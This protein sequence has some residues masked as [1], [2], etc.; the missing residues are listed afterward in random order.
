M[1]LNKLFI[2]SFICFFSLQVF[3]QDK[4]MDS[5]LKI[6]RT[7]QKDTIG[8]KIYFKVA[9]YYFNH[10]IVDSG[11]VYAKK[12]YSISQK[13][14]Y[15]KGLASAY[16]YFGQVF[17]YS[18]NKD[19]AIYYFSKAKDIF[20]SLQDSSRIAGMFNNMGVVYYKHGDIPKTLSLYFKALKIKERLHD[21]LSC[22]N[23]YYNI[24]NLY[25]EAS[26]TF[27]T[28]KY[29]QMALK[30]RMLVNDLSGIGLSNMAIGLYYQKAERFEQALPYLQKAL[31][32]SE[33]IGDEEAISIG[34]YNLA[35]VYYKQNKTEECLPL[36][37]RSLEISKKNKNYEGI[38]TCLEI[39]GKISLEKNNVSNGI[40][41]LQEAYSFARIIDNKQ[42]I[43]A[44]SN[45]LSS[46]LETKGDF[47]NALL[48]RKIWITIKDSLYNQEN[49]RKLTSEA[50]KYEH[51][52]ERIV[53][54][55]EQE[56][57]EA[58]AKSEGFKKDLIL[59]ASILF[60]IVVSIFTFI[61]LQRLK[62]N[63]KQKNIIEQ[64]RNEM[65]DSI[66]YA[67]RIQFALLAHTDLLKANLPQYFV[68]FRP[69]DIVSGDFYWATKTD[70]FF[71][72]AVCDSTGHGVPG[73]FMSLLNISFL[74]EAINEKN[75]SA[76]NEVLDHVRQRLL[77]NMDGG[78]DGMDAVL[79]KIPIDQP[80]S[81]IEY[82]AANNSPV[83]IRDNKVIELPKDK[84]PVGKGESTINF[85]LQ[86]IEV[87]SGDSFYIYTD[88]FADQFGGAKSKKFKY[89]QLDELLLSINGSS[90]KEQEEVLKKRFEDWMGK[91][92]QVDDV[93]VIGIKI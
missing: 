12:G 11:Y 8:A 38:A 22:S 55:K 36:F 47:K 57:K 67:K 21:T 77:E 34:S 35:S 62:E 65:I 66:N 68:L 37:N 23:S 48:Y 85:N 92:E 86:T 58:I 91:L 16:S 41:L 18:G 89:K 50:L 64:Q 31:T 75:I 26:D 93:C 17:T 70:K 3:S 78:H 28:L 71:Y 69:K 30:L 5:L 42:L 90:L 59:G 49:T 73:A 33:Q 7:H 60:L 53:L 14:N 87:R 63:R 83:L 13:V 79:V 24:G 74:N 54:E 6:G 82:A 61:I 45:N 1:R 19:S 40:K 56:K 81:V 84:M 25:S 80:V 9:S 44:I 29:H 46:A 15:V 76:P 10:G 51:E 43:S 32:I 88:G 4:D 20:S 27:N 39:L 2:V 72:L 52:K